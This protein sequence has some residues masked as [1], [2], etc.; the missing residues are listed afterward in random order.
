VLDRRADGVHPAGVFVAEDDGQVGRDDIGEP[1]VDDVQVGA[2]QPGAA[3]S[4]DHVLRP[5][6]LRFCHLVQA[7]RLSV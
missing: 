4:D 7:W 6:W 5:G 2:A 1:A 3:D